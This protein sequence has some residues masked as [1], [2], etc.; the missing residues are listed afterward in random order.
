M[1]LEY[2]P[3]YCF[4]VLPLTIWQIF[5][6]SSNVADIVAGEEQ[7]S[8]SEELIL[9]RPRKRPRV[10]NFLSISELLTIFPDEEPGTLATPA[11][12]HESLPS[13]IVQLMPHISA[14]QL[15]EYGELVK[16]TR[17]AANP[18]PQGLESSAMLEAIREQAARH[19]SFIW[20][21]RK[22]V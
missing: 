18:G 14:V 5:N 3:V 9:P 16:K 22:V 15:A 11:E 21:L 2:E 13:E 4:R 7:E 6:M 1:R 19:V 10:A 17:T 12:A 20:Q 8:S